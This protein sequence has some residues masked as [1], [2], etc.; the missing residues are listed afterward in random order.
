MFQQRPDVAAIRRPDALRIA[1]LSLLLSLVVG[2]I[3]AIG[4]V[5]SHERTPTALSAPTIAVATTSC[6][7]SRLA[8]GWRV[9]PL[10]GSSVPEVTGIVLDGLEAAL[11]LL[12]L[13]PFTHGL[14]GRV[15]GI[16]NPMI[17]EADGNLAGGVGAADEG[18]GD[19]GGRQGGGAAHKTT[20]TD[21]PGSHA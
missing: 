2:A 7:E 15:V 12:L 11:D 18:C 13:G 10:D 17:P 1:G 8:V 6:Q 20:T 19:H 14:L 9:G 4:L 5:I 3:L 21:F 16:G